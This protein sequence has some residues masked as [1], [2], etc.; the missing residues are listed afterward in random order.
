M[1]LYAEN[2]THTFPSSFL[3]AMSVLIDELIREKLGHIEGALLWI[4]PNA[5]MM[6][7]RSPKLQEN[8][9]IRR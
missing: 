2:P 8:V 5:C 1:H 3:P 7:I 4:W 6:L 9:H